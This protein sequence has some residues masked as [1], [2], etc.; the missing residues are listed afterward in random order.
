MPF[1][2]V[3]VGFVTQEYTVVESMTMFDVC[4]SLNVTTGVRIDVNLTVLPDTATC[5]LHLPCYI[6]KLYP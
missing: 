3:S 4:L 5:K 6:S 2:G 1:A